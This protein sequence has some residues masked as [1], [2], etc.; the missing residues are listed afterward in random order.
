V[1]ARTLLAVPLVSADPPLRDQVRAAR[2]A[3]ADLVELRVDCIND[4]AAVEALLA[5]PR[6]LPLILTVRAADEGGAWT[7]DDAERIALIE[8]LGLRLLATSP[9]AG[10]RDDYVDIEYATW[11]RSANIRQKVQLVAGATADASSAT[12][13][14]RNRLIISWHDFAGT[15]AD[16]DAVFERLAA[17]PADVLKAVFTAHD[18][19]DGFRVLSQLRRRAAAR[20][21]I[22]LALGEAGLFTRVLARKFGAFLTFAALRAAHA[23]APG[24][25]AIAELRGLYRWDKIG[26]GTRVYGVVGWPVSHSLSP[27]IHNAALSAANI[28]AVY[29]PLPVR[30]D[31]AGWAAFMEQAGGPG[32]DVAGLSVT[33]PH[34]EHALRWL[35][36]RGLP[37]SALAARC[38]AVNTLVHRPDGT[39]AG[40]NTD[41]RG[42]LAALQ[43]NARG[44]TGALRRARVDVLGAG[45]AAR[46][47]VAALRDCGC[48][49]TIYNRTAQRAA[50][51]ARELRCAWQP[52]D[53]RLHCGG[54]VLINCT[55]VGLWP[56]VDDSPLPDDAFRPGTL[57]FDTVY[58]PP[59]TRLL[60]AAAARGCE[61]VS[62]VEMFLA[63]AAAQ[64]ELWH[65]APAPAD[66]MR[67]A[68]QAAAQA[69]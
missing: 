6:D 19:T 54:D 31:A 39:W 24:Q 46:A 36:A 63:Q 38:G 42:A 66:V 58:R 18:A 17:T 60:R 21:L 35:A 7:G 16:L 53:A 40:D 62:G 2:D 44:R 23:S 27:V 9:S 47:V 26:P 57:V 41:A 67:V 10:Q 45:G 3:G 29:V 51:L 1:S 48:T 28:D 4:V 55:S 33:I 15:P 22:A 8:R 5:A 34:K 37:V 11:Q 25:P 52:W 32:L 50:E 49:V 43:A 59:Q 69:P 68:L 20:P 61:T 56:A 14:T 64:H 30:P 65:G 13:R 12:A